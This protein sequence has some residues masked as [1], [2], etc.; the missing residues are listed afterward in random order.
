MSSQDIFKLVSSGIITALETSSQIDSGEIAGKSGTFRR[1]EI[2]DNNTKP[3]PAIDLLLENA[4][5]TSDNDFIDINVYIRYLNVFGTGLPGSEN[6]RKNENV[7][8]TG[9]NHGLL[10]TINAKKG[11]DRNYFKSN[12]TITQGYFTLY[13]SPT[14]GS[15]ASGAKLK[16]RKVSGAPAYV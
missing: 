6:S 16:I 3:W 13:F 14:G 8:E 10:C 5:I 11:N 15:I 7:P 12:L 4:D 1:Q 2:I 9:K